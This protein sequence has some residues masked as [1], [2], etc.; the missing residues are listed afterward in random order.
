MS[1][2]S[3]AT[4]EPWRSERFISDSI[5]SITYQRLYKP[6]SASRA[7]TS[8]STRF[9]MI[10]SIFS[11]CSCATRASSS[12]MRFTSAGIDSGVLDPSSSA[13]RT[14]HRSSENDRRS[15]GETSFSVCAFLERTD[16][17]PL[18]DAETVHAGADLVAA[19]HS[20]VAGRQ[21]IEVRTVAA[22]EVADAHVAV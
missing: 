16:L 1:S 13:I 21:G 15:I 11:R 20:R 7:D 8:A 9:F 12:V 18:L 3:S 17:M 6:V 4:G 14:I 5:F 10:R 2:I 19:V 22:A